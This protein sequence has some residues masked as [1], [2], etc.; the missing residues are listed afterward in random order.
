MPSKPIPLT[1]QQRSSL[2]ELGGASAIAMNVCRDSTG[3]LIRRPG[4][5]FSSASTSSKIDAN[6]ISAVHSA[7][8]GDIY[9]TGAGIVSSNIYKISG[10]GYTALSNNLSETLLG[11]LRP[12]IAETGAL[13]VLTAGDVPQK[14]VLS[15]D[16]SSRLG[17]SPPKATHVISN[18]LRLLLNDPTVDTS[19]VRYSSVATGTVYTGHEVWTYSG[20]SG[21]ITAESRPDPVV[22]LGEN[23]NTV[24]IFGQTTLQLF[25]PDP[26]WT[27]SP[28]NTINIGC[29]APYSIIRV[30]ES[31]AWMDDKR[32][33][34]VSDGMSYSPISDDIAE[35]LKNLTTVTDGFG[36]RVYEPPV[37]CMVWTFPT[38][39]KTF[40]R[41]TEGGWSQWSKRSA[42]TGM[43]ERLGVNCHT[44]MVSN[45]KNIVGTNSGYVAELTK[46]VETD[47]DVPIESY[48]E[49][50]FVSRGTTK[51]K[52]CNCVS[53]MMRRDNSAGT[54]RMRLS[55]ADEPNAWCDPIWIEIS[56]GTDK[57]PVVNLRSLGVYR[58]RNWRIEL[59][60][61]NE[62]AIVGFIEDYEELGV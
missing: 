20:L 35:D 37:D 56:A 53:I 45:G 14:V 60:E 41:Q 44:Y 11:T 13:L 3:T 8:N 30:D 15:T 57:Y 49:S 47:F 26:T 33:I 19:Q 18:S 22:A 21:S 17:G 38:D 31:F 39:G 61:S 43:W 55:Y 10:G 23:T 36:Y 50:G 7:Y 62:M 2:E 27:F 54:Q 48:V 1:N 46:S 42:T 34:V 12:S 16:I 6:G 24:F 58:A 29:S 32:R 40:C 9:A 28:A 52:K 5:A 59:S 25:S 4:L 51:R